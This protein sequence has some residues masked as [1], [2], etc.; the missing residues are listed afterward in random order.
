MKNPCTTFLTDLS[1][2]IN[3]QNDELVKMVIDME[4]NNLICAAVDTSYD[5]YSVSLKKKIMSL[6]SNLSDCSSLAVN[7]AL[8]GVDK[9][10]EKFGGINITQLSDN[11][12]ESILFL[13][14]MYISSCQCNTKT[15]FSAMISTL[16][17]AYSKKVA[18][19]AKGSNIDLEKLIKK[20]LVEDYERFKKVI[21]DLKT[22]K[23]DYS[24][25]YQN[26]MSGGNITEQLSI[27]GE[28]NSLIPNELGAMKEYFVNIIASYY[29]KL[30]P[31][32]WAQI[33]K[34]AI[35]NFTK[36]APM[37]YFELFSF[38]SKCLLV[39][40]G[41]YI[42]KI[43]QLVRP[44]LSMELK[45]K[46]NL[47]NS[48]YPLMTDH[49][50]NM[51]CDKVFVKRDGSP[52]PKK[53]Y[54]KVVDFSASVG[55]VR[56]FQ[57]V[58]LDK[59]DEKK[60]FILK[61]IKPLSIVQ[62]CWERSVLAPLHTKGSCEYNF[63][64]NMIESNGR[65]MNVQNEKEN[66]NR[67]YDIY[68][69]TY[70]DAFGFDSG[71]S[72]TTLE[73]IDDII[74]E[75]VWYALTVTVAD[76]NPLSNFIEKH[77]HK[78]EES[79]YLA[80][81][82]RCFDLLVYKFFQGIMTDGFYHGD[83]HA[84]NI[85]FSYSKKKMTLIDLGA[86]GDL[87][88]FDTSSEDVAEKM[89]TLVRIFCKFI[90]GDFV[91][92]LGVLSK[93]INTLCPVRDERS[94]EPKK[95]NEND[96]GYKNLEKV[97]AEFEAFNIANK[98]KNSKITENNREKIFSQDAIDKENYE[99]SNIVSKRIE[100][101]S[102]YDYLDLEMPVKETIEESR[103]TDVISDNNLEDTNS[104]SLVDVLEEIFKYYATFGVNIAIK[105]GDL[106]EFQ[107][108]YGLI[109]GVAKQIKY[110]SV[111]MSYAIEKSLL[112]SSSI[113]PVISHPFKSIEYALI[114]KEEANLKK[115]IKNK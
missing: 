112:N 91:G 87:Q 82:H 38:G 88:I 21:E 50:V 27:R 96:E 32:I 110:N 13:L 16:G 18:D 57:N 36:E 31:I 72:L 28:L 102:M 58:T 46:Y 23:I 61:I 4:S 64:M 41:P 44:V 63:V 55:H 1:D 6:L 77:L 93:Y 79:R 39:N 105:F 109:L 92:I 94:S 68:T 106:Y 37:S 97:L 25:R 19:K 108:A 90:N 103:L 86:V 114:Y 62:S 11:G 113:K 74:D 65:E 29:E 45:Q 34:A 20:H 98:D 12:L 59:T 2:I 43:L 53:I 104:K 115:N 42:L 40:S 30:H 49:Q 24:K 3:S 7:V 89:K 51:I 14:R 78:D 81:L 70:S 67:A 69:S 5:A 60:V 56:L 15:I 9:G 83:L 71:H 75:K 48:S 101:N 54:K 84:G 47:V 8:T 95:V 52:D 10:F 33:I 111:R 85:F 80:S 76:G 22:Y 99:V 26:S 35:D 107:K 100:T 66:I 73:N 17:T